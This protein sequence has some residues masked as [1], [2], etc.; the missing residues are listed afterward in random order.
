M[1]QGRVQAEVDFRNSYFEDGKT[2]NYRPRAKKSRKGGA[3]VELGDEERNVVFKS[4]EINLGDKKI[5]N[6]SLDK[7][8]IQYLQIQLK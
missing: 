5:V 2:K 6:F 4:K 3:L 8:Q 1:A 7:L